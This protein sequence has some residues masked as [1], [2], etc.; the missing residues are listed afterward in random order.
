VGRANSDADEAYLRLWQTALYPADQHGF[1]SGMFG[2]FVFD[3]NASSYGL[4]A[5]DTDDEVEL[6][7]EIPDFIPNAL[8]QRPDKIEGCSLGTADAKQLA[9]EI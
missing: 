2:P 8:I 1:N 6:M 3:N 9:E 4:L 5:R 7:G